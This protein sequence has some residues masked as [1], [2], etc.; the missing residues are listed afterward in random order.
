MSQAKELYE[1]LT[2]K[3]RKSSKNNHNHNNLF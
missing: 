1:C 3:T 2:S